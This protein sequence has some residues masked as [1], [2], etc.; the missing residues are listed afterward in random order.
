M[1]Q[2]CERTLFV[3]REW[4][5]QADKVANRTTLAMTVGIGRGLQESTAHTSSPKPTD[6]RRGRGWGG[7]EQL[8]YTSGQRL[9]WM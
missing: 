2:V 9:G 5:V 3:D 1:E 6:G 8:E 7:C 4:S